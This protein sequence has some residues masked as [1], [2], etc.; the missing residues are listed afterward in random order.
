MLP[1]QGSWVIELMKSQ[2]GKRLLG[3]RGWQS[4][5][6]YLC[7]P[8]LRVSECLVFEAH[9]FGFFIRCTHHKVLLLS[10]LQMQK[11]C[12]DVLQKKVS[13]SNTHA[14][15]E[16]K[17]RLNRLCDAKGTFI[18][19]FGNTFASRTA[20]E[21]GTRCSLR[22]CSSSKRYIILMFLCRYLLGEC[23]FD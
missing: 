18:L 14:S 23:Y 6:N 2:P 3:E 7:W 16:F 15:V 4:F 9:H 12:L 21:S 17:S 19:G 10:I 5:S 8:W 11:P 20:E 13:N 22:A 1:L